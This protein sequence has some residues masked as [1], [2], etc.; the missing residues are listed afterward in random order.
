M[1]KKIL[2]C[3]FALLL[4]SFLSLPFVFPGSLALAHTGTGVLP[5]A[6]PTLDPA[7]ILN[8]ANMAATQAA[9]AA[10]RSDDASVT[11]N[12]VASDLNTALVLFSVFAAI[13][14]ALG[15]VVW[16]EYIKKT[17]QVNSSLKAVDD[18]IVRVKG[19]V[20]K[21][22]AQLIEV[23]NG[24]EGRVN[25]VIESIPPQ[26]DVL[27][28]EVTYL[29]R[30]YQLL[31]LKRKDQAKR[32]FQ[33]ALDARPEDPQANYALGRI[34]SGDKLYTEAIAYFRKALIPIPIFLK[35]RWS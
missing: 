12:T 16:G 22:N 23:T 21:T 32:A 15:T 20:G 30:G 3:I 33:L 10:K 9:D 29:L 34:Y 6:T 5:G 31:E 18:A 13:L 11:V 27:R 7:Q 1:R 26:V 19:L 28:K 35:R 14:G 2:S 4:L 24:A 25:Q 8:E 17:A